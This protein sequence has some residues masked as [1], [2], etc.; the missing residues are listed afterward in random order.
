MVLFGFFTKLSEAATTKK[1]MKKQMK[2]KYSTWEWKSLS[3]R[4]FFFLLLK[5]VST[6]SYF[7]SCTLT[8]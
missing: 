4:K 1:L 2:S 3:W 5:V 7:F 8:L 6:F